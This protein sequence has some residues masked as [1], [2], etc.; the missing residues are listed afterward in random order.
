M[1]EQNCTLYNFEESMG[2]TFAEFYN[3]PPSIRKNIR[4]KFNEMCEN[5]DD[6]LV[7][8]KSI[9]QY[10]KEPNVNDERRMRKVCVTEQHTKTLN[11]EDEFMLPYS[12]NHCYFIN[13]PKNDISAFNIKFDNL[14]LV[15]SY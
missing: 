3:S 7:M 5:K 13:K 6:G 14:Y 12:P 1:F 15:F 8:I 10:N 11:I 4:T 9:V 2:C